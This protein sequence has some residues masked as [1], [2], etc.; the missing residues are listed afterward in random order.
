MHVASLSICQLELRQQIDSHVA[1]DEWYDLVP[2]KLQ[3]QSLEKRY[4]GY[5]EI[6]PSDRTILLTT[7]SIDHAKSLT[8]ETEYGAEH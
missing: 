2:D 3:Q 4:E 8:K 1:G 6:E 7:I 5:V